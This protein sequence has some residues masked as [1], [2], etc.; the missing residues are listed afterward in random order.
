[1][2][3]TII[4]KATLKSNIVLFHF[5]N[6]SLNI[7]TNAETKL[8]Y[9]NF[10][11]T[12]QWIFYRKFLF[13]IF[14]FFFCLLVTTLTLLS[15]KHF[16]FHEIKLLIMILRQR[17]LT[18]LFFTVCLSVCIGTW[19][20]KIQQKKLNIIFKKKLF[21]VLRSI[22]DGF[23]GVAVKFKTV[24]F[25]VSVFTLKNFFLIFFYYVLLQ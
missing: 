19:P 13:N 9:W 23:S 7:S 20:V 6:N 16:F 15:R 25:K 10:L 17:I 14:W 12:K 21:V 3:E 22:F 18:K 5:H 8:S 1:M 24:G 4:S 11:A 2:N